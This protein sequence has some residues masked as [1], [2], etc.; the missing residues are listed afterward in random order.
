MLGVMAAAMLNTAVSCAA[1]S[2]SLSAGDAVKQWQRDT[3]TSLQ[4]EFDDVV[5]VPTRESYEDSVA[6]GEKSTTVI[7]QPVAGR[8]KVSWVELID[9]HKVRRYNT[10]FSI[11]A[12][13]NVWV[14]E[15]D[16]NAGS[17]IK[18]QDVALKKVNVAPF[19]GIKV[20]ADTDPTDKK[21]Q[22]R[23][24]KGQIVFREYLLDKPLIN[25]NDRVTVVLQQ[26]GLKIEMDAVA[27]EDAVEQGQ[28]IKVRSVSGGATLTGVVKE[29]NR[30]YVDE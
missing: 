12:Y 14:F 15:R 17:L 9:A 18:S 8:L 10:S 1:V 7:S 22:T 21:L 6:V 23:S 3:C 16:L 20:F 2:S 27:L 19:L 13:K 30:V 26:A 5:L 4:K 24:K 29:N 11:E 28:K 25:R